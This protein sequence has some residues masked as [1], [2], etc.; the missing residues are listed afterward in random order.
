MFKLLIHPSAEGVTV[1]RDLSTGGGD[2]ACVVEE[3]R[4]E[5][6][7][8]GSY[9]VCNIIIRRAIRYLHPWMGLLF[10]AMLEP[11]LCLRD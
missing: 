5:I 1:A 8:R 6:D 10:V 2:S 4:Y 3:D 11:Y 7:V 9:S